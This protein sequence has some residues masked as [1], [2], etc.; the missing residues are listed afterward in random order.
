MTFSL[1]RRVRSPET[2]SGSLW[3]PY[4]RYWASGAASLLAFV[5]CTVAPA[6]VSSAAAPP[7]DLGAAIELMENGRVEDAQRLLEELLANAETA[8]GRDLLGVVLSRQQRFAEAEAQFV[9]ALE[10]DSSRFETHQNLGR[11]Y[12]QLERPEQALPALRTAAEIGPLERELALQLA[13]AEISAGNVAAAER[14]LRSVIERFESVRAMLDLARI[15]A[16]RGDSDAASQTIRRALELAPNSE[17]VLSAF[18]RLSLAQRQPVPAVRALEPLQRMHPSVPD[19]PYLLGVARLQIGENDGAIEALHRALELQPHDPKTLT[20]LGLAFNNQKQFAEARDVLARSVEIDPDNYEGLAALAE[21]EEG[22]GELESAERHAL[23]ALALSAD[24]SGAHLALGKI[25]MNRQ[26]HLGARDALEQAVAADP[27]SAK[28]HY[29]LSLAYARLG[30]VEKSRH[31]LELYRDAL[32]QTENYLI[33]L[34]T[35]A[36]LGVEDM[37]P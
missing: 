21:A 14:Q 35:R 17:E 34:R 18:A 32:K 9:R 28:A 27:T 3:Q 12:L 24:H 37:R 10:L 23:A 26:E 7:S 19:Y 5:V 2:D 29:Q 20:A 22:L 8:A 31:H 25:R 1:P 6:T 16:R 13:A 15:E 33:E 30:E 11:L 4:R 36:G